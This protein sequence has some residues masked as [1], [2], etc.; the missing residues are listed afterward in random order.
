MRRLWPLPLLMFGLVFLCLGLAYDV[1]FA[2]LPYQDPTPELQ[3]GYEFHKGVA[4]LIAQVGLGALALGLFGA[5]VQALA[6]R[7]QA[8]R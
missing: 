1:M 7:T 8:S 5:V 6:R 3:A 2:G 4:A